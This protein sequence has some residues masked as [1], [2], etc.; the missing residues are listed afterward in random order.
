MESHAVTS[1]HAGEVTP[2]LAV[3]SRA[4][5]DTAS[6]GA[7]VAGQQ[8]GGR[9]PLELTTQDANPQP[10]QR[11]PRKPS[12]AEQLYQQVQTVRQQQCLKA[13][14]PFTPDY[15]PEARQNKDLGPVVRVPPGAPVDEEG[16]PEAFRRFEAAF[17]EYL[18][19][20]FHAAKGWPLAL[21][22]TGTVRARYEQ[23]AALTAQASLREAS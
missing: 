3:P 6:Q 4:V 12:A 16:R 7:A 20:D 8:P 10:K 18:S 23:A 22:L 21:F 2:S 15:M 11:A 9:P 14:V 1:S 13:G 19:D 17:A 5:P